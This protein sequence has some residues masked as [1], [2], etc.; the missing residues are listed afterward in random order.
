MIEEL[1]KGNVNQF[2]AWRIDNPSIRLDC[3]GMD[4][5]GMNLRDAI[6]VNIIFDNCNFK[7]T[8][9]QRAIL[10]SSSFLNCNF[11]SALLVQACIGIPELIDVNLNAEYTSYLL[12]GAICDGSKFDNANLLLAN[13]RQTSLKNCRFPDAILVKCDMREADLTN[14][15]FEY[16]TMEDIIY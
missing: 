1:K 4:F 14:T 16:A 15:S 6:L 9:L 10:C 8:I 3:S 7:F 12:H 2:N 11:D 5:S 13:L